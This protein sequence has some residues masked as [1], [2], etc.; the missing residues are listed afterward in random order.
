MFLQLRLKCT[1]ASRQ[2]T[3]GWLWSQQVAPVPLSPL[4]SSWPSSQS[5]QSAHRGAGTTSQEHGGHGP[6]PLVHSSAAAV[7][8]VCLPLS[9]C[10][11]LSFSTWALHSCREHASLPRH[12]TA[13]RRNSEAVKLTIPSPHYDQ[14][15]F[16]NGATHN[17]HLWRNIYVCTVTVPFNTFSKNTIYINQVESSAWGQM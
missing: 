17:R 3:P 1:F 8:S 16:G 13:A 7:V 4:F 6:I 15:N 10:C 14:F 9:L 11:P 2:V 12:S 5:G